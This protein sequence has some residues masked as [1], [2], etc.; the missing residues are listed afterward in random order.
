MLP[1]AIAVL[2]DGENEVPF[3]SHKGFAV[4][5]RIGGGK[6]PRVCEREETQP[7]L[8]VADKVTV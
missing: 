5:L 7:L 6:I 2:V 3:I 4:K 1:E 8:L